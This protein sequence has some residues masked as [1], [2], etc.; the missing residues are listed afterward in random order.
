MSEQYMQEIREGTGTSAA[1]AGFWRR[2]GAALIDGII[3]GIVY[4]VVLVI[5]NEGLALGAYVLL[6]VAYFTYLEGSSGQTIG[7]KGVGI[8]VV[9]ISGGGPIGD[10]RAFVRYIG[11]IVSGIPI[12]L[13][14]LWMLWDPQKQT[15]HDKFAKSVVVPESS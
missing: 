11:R 6:S 12:Y 9:D 4:G 15:W 1:R 2:A 13:G 14:Y 7:K 3:L 5:S 8:K 10:G